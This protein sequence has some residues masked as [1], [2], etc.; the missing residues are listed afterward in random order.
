MGEEFRVGFKDGTLE[1]R[2]YDADTPESPIFRSKIH[3]GE[4]GSATKEDALDTLAE[5]LVDRGIPF[6]DRIEPILDRGYE[7]LSE[8][9]WGI[10]FMAANKYCQEK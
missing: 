10:L 7:R 4:S 8:G 9:E 1:A 6:V 3:F 5:Q 2:F